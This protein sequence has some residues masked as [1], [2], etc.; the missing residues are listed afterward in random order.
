[1]S[2]SGRYFQG[3][4]SGAKKKEVARE[5]AIFQQW[6]HSL[7]DYIH[8]FTIFTHQLSEEDILLTGSAE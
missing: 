6:I 2:R 8:T 1:L 7:I 5:R 3:S 4:K